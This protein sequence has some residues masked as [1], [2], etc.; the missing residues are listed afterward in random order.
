MARR[1]LGL[2][3]RRRAYQAA[4]EAYLA[5]GDEAAMTANATAEVE[6]LGLPPWL[7]AILV[8]IAV[9]LLRK[10]L[11]KKLS[12]PT[13]FDS[14]DDAEYDIEHDLAEEDPL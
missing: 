2:F 6:G 9:E 3:Y 14:Q 10:W 7:V 5:G 1:K 12:S 4:K 8:Q 11:E 13:E